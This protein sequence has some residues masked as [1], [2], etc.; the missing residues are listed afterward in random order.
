MIDW[1]FFY[2]RYLHNRRTFNGFRW[3]F[4]LPGPI[5]NEKETEPFIMWGGDL[6]VDI[7]ACL[8]RWTLP[9]SRIFRQT[10]AFEPSAK[11]YEIL[12][13][14]VRINSLK[15][16]TCENSAV[17]DREGIGCLFSDGVMG[18]DLYVRAIS[19]HKVQL[20]WVAPIRTEYD[21]GAVR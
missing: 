21:L 19:I 12:K 13:R 1:R 10:I 11:A 2:H 17:S 7:G 14:H 18:H 4:D 15:N 9:A 20:G 3:D 6:F 16:V 8:G 5:D